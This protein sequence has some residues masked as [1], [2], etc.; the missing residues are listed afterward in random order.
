MASGKHISSSLARVACSWQT[1]LFLQESAAIHPQLPAFLATV[2]CL[3][4]SVMEVPEESA[5]LMCSLLVQSSISWLEM[6]LLPTQLPAS[7]QTLKLSEHTLRGRFFEHINLEQH[8]ETLLGRLQGL[9]NLW[10]LGLELPCSMPARF[11][12]LLPPSLASV[13]ISIAILPHA[14]YSVDELA[15]EVAR[16]K[17]LD[18]GALKPEGVG[19]TQLPFELYLTARSSR[20]TLPAGS[21]SSIVHDALVSVLIGTAPVH[22]ALLLPHAGMRQVCQGLADLSC[23]S[24]LLMISASENDPSQEPFIGFPKCSRL[25]LV[26]FGHL[27]LAWDALFDSGMNVCCLGSQYS[28]PETRIEV[29]G[30]SGLPQQRPCALIVWGLDNVSGLPANS[31]IL[32]EEHLDRRKHVW[33]TPAAVSLQL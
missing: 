18:L 23:H 33:R 17:Q 11:A 24:C 14:A 6:G 31:F 4:V 30:C 20:C 3:R 25:E 2:G 13:G 22:L 27:R 19:G 26:G 15:Q 9:P 32:E 28:L 29:L 5:S 16:V 8:L 21:D 7:L 10:H 1:H 12:A